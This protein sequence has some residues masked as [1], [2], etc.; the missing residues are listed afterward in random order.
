MS[1]VERRENNGLIIHLKSSIILVSKISMLA[2]CGILEK[3][4]GDVLNCIWIWSLML[5][6]FDLE[7]TDWWVEFAS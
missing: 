4:G 1:D 6:L 5:E 3:C 2:G 7:M